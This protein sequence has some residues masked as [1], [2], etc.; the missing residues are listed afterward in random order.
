MKLLIINI[1]GPTIRQIIIIRP[2]SNISMLDR[3]LIHL[4]TPVIAEIIDSTV[5]TP[6]SNNLIA[7]ISGNP[8]KM[9][10]P[11]VTCKVGISSEVATPATVAKI[12]NISI[13][14]PILPLAFV[15][16][17]NGINTLLFCAGLLCLNCIYTKAKIP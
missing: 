7:F 5:I 14:L 9:L 10:K 3:Y 15:S 11:L 12:T 6:I 16:P 8:N 13:N 1:V 2:A 4:L 17:I